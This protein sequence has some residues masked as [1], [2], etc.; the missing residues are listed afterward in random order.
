[1]CL[2]C[3]DWIRLY[4]DIEVNTAV[5]DKQLK[6]ESSNSDLRCSVPALN[7]RPMT[8]KNRTSR[9]RS[10][11][12]VHL[13]RLDSQRSNENNFDTLSHNSDDSSVGK[14]SSGP[15][16]FQRFTKTFSLRF[17]N[18]S[19]GINHGGRK[20]KKLKYGVGSSPDLYHRE[21]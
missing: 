20:T 10:T 13:H 14:G 21:E 7:S 12:I 5:K 3:S 8:D 6:R 19:S 4:R 15:S 1:M 18:G 2:I 17:G 16:L 9:G 11:S